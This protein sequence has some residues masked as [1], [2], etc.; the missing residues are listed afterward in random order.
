MTNNPLRGQIA[1]P[2]FHIRRRCARDRLIADATSRRRRRTLA[3][4]PGAIERPA[5]AH[6]RLRVPRSGGSISH[7]RVMDPGRG[8]GGRRRRDLRD[9]ENGRTSKWPPSSSNDWLRADH[10]RARPVVD[11]RP[12]LRM[13][14]HRSTAART[15]AERALT[16]KRPPAP[17]SLAPVDPSARATSPERNDPATVHSHDARDPKGYFG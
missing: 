3:R 17:T 7:R 4:W 2:V 11:R 8:S 5:V 15:D 1:P 9:P 14:A 16:A 13:E 10:A 12:A 6:S